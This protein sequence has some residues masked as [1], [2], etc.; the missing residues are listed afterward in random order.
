MQIIVN[1]IFNHPYLTSGKD[2]IARKIIS[3]VNL[4]ECFEKAYKLE[5]SARY[6][7]YMHHKFADLDV[8][9]AY[10]EWCVNGITIDLFYGNATVD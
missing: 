2:V 8:E 4:E 5:R 6:N 1:E 10:K 3:G 9:K 7:N